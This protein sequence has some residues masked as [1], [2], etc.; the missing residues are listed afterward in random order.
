[1]GAEA[2]GACIKRADVSVVTTFFTRL[3]IIRDHISYVV[4]LASIIL[5]H[6]SNS[7][8]LVLD[9]RIRKALDSAATIRCR[10]IAV[11]DQ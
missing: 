1:M 4:D 10:I 9:K 6:S 2:I 7:L 5:T 8:S 3:V 11:F